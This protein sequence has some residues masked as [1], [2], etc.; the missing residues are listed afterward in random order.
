MVESSIGFC[1]R[2]VIMIV[3]T[4]HKLDISVLALYLVLYRDHSTIEV[5]V[6]GISYPPL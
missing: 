3:V 1:L 6:Y 2:G 5:L 4:H